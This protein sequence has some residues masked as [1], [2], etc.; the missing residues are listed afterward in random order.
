MKEPSGLPGALP[1]VRLA[2]LLLLCF[3]LYFWN[4]S[5]RDLWPSHE[6]RAAQNA[7]LILDEGDWS[8]PRLFD[9]QVE[10]QKP[11][12]YYWLVAAFGS[13]NDGEVTAWSVRLPAAIAGLLTVLAVAV[14]FGAKLRAGLLAGAILATS[15]HFVGMARVGRIDMVLTLTITVLLLSCRERPRILV[16]GVLLALA[17]LLKGLIALALPVGVL[18]VWYLLEKKSRWDRLFR[19]AAMTLVGVGLAAPWFWVANVRTD[20]EFVRSFFWHHHFQRAFG[21]SDSLAAH[22]WWFY[23]PRFLIDFMPWTPLVIWMWLRGAGFRPTDPD[24]RLEAHP[25]NRDERFA[26]VWFLVVFGLLSLSRFKRSDYLLPAFPAAAMWLG[27]RLSSA[28]TVP[29]G[30]RWP[31]RSF[32]VGIA[33]AIIGLFVYDLGIAPRE[34]AV[35]DQPSFAKFVRLQVP[36]PKVVHFFRVE[37]HLLAFHVGRPI[38]SLVEWHDLNDVLRE[39]GEHFFLTREEFVPECQRHVTVRPLEVVVSSREFTPEK[40]LRPLV[41]MRT[42][43]DPSHEISR[44]PP[45]PPTPTD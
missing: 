20:G 23:G 16:G 33:S 12:L 38:H 26:L 42:R 21:G 19:L 36:A 18:G 27:S 30:S 4:L 31:S 6:A 41:L 14:S 29:G 17:I 8:L 45:L 34:G 25:T 43:S 15:M 24:G 35:R 3:L 39:P 22:P 40:P 9:A 32:R 11:P 13:L 2:I 5:A 37:S 44:C 10:T 7:Q 28:I 1:P